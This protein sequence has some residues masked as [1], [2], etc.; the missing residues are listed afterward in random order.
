MRAHLRQAR[1]SPKKAN[2]IAAMVRGLHAPEALSLLEKLPK[3]GATILH[4]L[5]ASAIAN[6]TNNASQKPA[7]LVI[8][9][10][11]VNKGPAYRRYIPM[12]RGRSRPIDKWTSHI[13][14]ELGVE[15]GDQER[16]EEKG[17]KGKKRV[18]GEKKVKD[19][20]DIVYSANKPVTGEYHQKAFAPESGDSDT[21]ESHGHA[22]FQ[23]QRKGSRG[24]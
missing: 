17:V 7:Q 22:T 4:A 9:R 16:G 20:S 1:I 14:V 24:S 5:L 11:I 8:R 13:T 3:K 21:K 18:K 19:E 23:P 12:A 6:A 2:L 10:L 15:M